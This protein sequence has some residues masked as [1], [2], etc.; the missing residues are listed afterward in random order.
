[1]ARRQRRVDNQQ[2]LDEGEVVQQ[3]VPMTDVIDDGESDA[4]S[5][6]QIK[7]SVLKTHS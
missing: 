3:E 7:I 4:F 1:M 2:I 6:G 5:V